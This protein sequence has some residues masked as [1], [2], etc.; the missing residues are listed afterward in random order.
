MI[1]DPAVPRRDALLR[2]ETMAALSQRLPTASRSSAASAGT[3]STASARACASST[4]APASG[5]PPAPAGATASP[6][7]RSAP[8]SIP[9][10]HDRK[11]DLA[12]VGRLLDATA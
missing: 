4:A 2:P 7:P 12:A 10:P 8:R 11:L 5:S 1:P 6:P 9:F 3:S